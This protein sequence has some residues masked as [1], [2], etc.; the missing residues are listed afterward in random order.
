MGLIR[1]PDG[2]DFV[3]EES[4][5]DRETLLDTAEWINAYRREHDQSADLENAMEII[6]HASQQRRR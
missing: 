1:E 3:V 2:V 4:V 6:R 5:S